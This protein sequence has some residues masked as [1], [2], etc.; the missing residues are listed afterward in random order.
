MKMRFFNWEQAFKETPTCD[1]IL[2]KVRN[3]EI[4]YWIFQ[5]IFVTITLAGFNILSKTP[6]SDLEQRAIGF[7]LLV[8]GGTHIA[9]MK[10]W[11]HIKLTMYFMI[12]DRENRL[13]AEMKKMEAQDL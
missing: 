1:D 2:K 10:I 3:T 13:E 4:K 9:V 5:V 6:T 11:A 8:L 12:W 7:L